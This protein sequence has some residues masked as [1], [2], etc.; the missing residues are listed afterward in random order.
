MTKIKDWD[1][2]FYNESNGLRNIG[3]SYLIEPLPS[4]LINN[5]KHNLHGYQKEALEDFIFY[6]EAD[7]NP[8]TKTDLRDK[9]EPIHA[10]FN[11]ATG[12]GKTLIMAANI[13]YFIKHG[14]KKF[15][16][17][18]HQ[19]NILNKTKEN[20]SNTYHQKYLFNEKIVIDSNVININEVERFGNNDNYEI[21]FTTI[22]Q[23][24]ID[25]DETKI[26][27][28]RND[29]QDLNKLDIVILADEAHHFNTQTT[30]K[31]KTE[32][33]NWENTLIDKVFNKEYKFKN[34]N[35]VL[36]EYTAT[37]PE[38]EE[39]QKKYEGKI[40]YKFDLKKF[41]LAELTKEINL[42]A[43]NLDDR[44][45]TK[46]D[47]IIYALTFNWLRHKVA[48]ENNIPNFK[49]V[50]L[51]RRKSIEESMED[52]EFFLTLVKALTVEDL[53]FLN[54]DIPQTTNS[55]SIHEQGVKR[56]EQIIKLLSLEENKNDFINYVKNNFKRDINVVITN[57]KTNKKKEE[58]IDDDLEKKLN[59]LED[60]N[61]TIRAIFT[62]KRLTEG[63]DV[64]NL[65]DIVRMDT[66]QNSGGS[67]IKNTKKISAA[68]I[69]EKQLI[70][71]AVRFNPFKLNNQTFLKR[72][73]DD[74]LNNDLRILEEF[75]FFTQDDDKYRYIRDL[76][77][78]LS[79]DGYLKE[80]EE[81]VE[82]RLKKSFT[83]KP[84]Y[85][86]ASLFINS[87]IEGKDYYMHSLDEL[88]KDITIRLHELNI[89]EEKLEVDKSSLK[90]KEN[91]K[92]I[93]KDT[94]EI[95]LKIKNF[96]NHVIV[97]ALYQMD[98]SHKKILETLNTNTLKNIKNNEILNKFNIRLTSSHE[99]FESLSNKENKFILEKFFVKILNDLS[100]QLSKKYGEKTFRPILL[101][102]VFSKPKQK[103]FQESKDPMKSIRLL[104]EVDTKPWY[105]IETVNKDTQNKIDFLPGSS[106]ELSFIELFN[107]SFAKKLENIYEEFYLIR[108]EEV[109]KIYDFETGE[110]FQPD[111]ILMLKLSD[112]LF[113][114]VFIEPK[115]MK[116]G[117]NKSLFNDD[118]KE[119]FLKTIDSIHGI[120]GQEL[121]VKKKAYHLIG[122]PFY[123]SE[124]EGRFKEKFENI[125]S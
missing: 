34:N 23:L 83:K 17:V 111:F 54:I 118:W 26:R 1:D 6:V 94:E 99:S 12:S 101:S 41:M 19:T 82:Y 70:G 95:I 52:Y 102:D 96:D 59:N 32:N 47:K 110:G 38:N 51:F 49:P 35:N 53:K 15:L 74:D 108:N 69:E 85:K 80:H 29:Q 92:N 90:F 107:N 88:E 9:D 73:Y 37:V 18:T 63:W 64:Q 67:T 97:K 86:N 112:N 50:I 25:L 123:N 5:L 8:K 91:S 75:F 57:S 60:P 28:N 87:Q 104:S 55:N 116:K 109:F 42:V 121:Y 22:Q 24:H 46:K 44:E 11:M 39:I 77:I 16:F 66:G 20:L 72:Q 124:H 100:I 106:E 79:K 62:V 125:I 122:L 40:I 120:N 36:I 10:M 105:V 117:E 93:K 115:G 2:Y 71:R 31:L 114:I 61:N 119:E 3:W 58:Q 4:Y 113:Y 84:F 81:I 45:E 48:L 78:E 68:T 21:K 89:V 103:L 65:F 76:K 56:T 13:L 14:Y 33:D 7:E 98:L 43:M 27:E 30:K